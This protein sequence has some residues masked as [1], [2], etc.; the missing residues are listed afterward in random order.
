MKRGDIWTVADGKDYA[1][2]PRPVV[3]VQD[4]S[5]DAT[6]SI[7]VCAVTTD[8]TEA[9]L[10]RLAVE[11]NQ[12]NGLRAAS[13]LMVDKITT[14]PKAKVGAR[15]GR[16]DDEDILRVH[17]LD[18]WQK[19]CDLS[20]SPEEIGQVEIPI[21][22]VVV[23]LFWWA[24]GGTILASEEAL[25]DGACVHL[26]GGFHHAFPSYGAG[27][28]LINDIAVSL[29]TLL[30]KEMIGTAAV[31][32]CDLHQ[33]DGTAS[34]FREDPRVFTMSIHQR[35]AFPFIK[36]HSTLDVEL[37]DGIADEAYLEAL[38]SALGTVFDGRRYYDLVHYQAGAD[39]Y[40]GDTLGGL[41][42]SAE[43]LLKR[44]RLVLDAAMKAGSPV[45]V[46]L[47]GG[48]PVDVA[49]VVQIHTHTVLATR[50][51]LAMRGSLDGDAG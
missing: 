1:G 4:D 28:C 50:E 41:R 16:L 8:E 36:Q 48:Y 49:D 6:D 32:D 2:K 46:T 42:L 47:G 39:P 12:R 10:F 43:G 19:L 30:D 18:Y 34:I 24:A 17:T 9:P 13:R 31:I 29:R 22:Q 21:S 11:P 35:R 26:G 20:F 33:G 3:I 15:V 37:E 14:V 45:V 40:A 38:A 7:T 25:K 23:D 51:A 5:F 44:D 27:F